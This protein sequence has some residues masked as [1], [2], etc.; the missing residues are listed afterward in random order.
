MDNNETPKSEQRSGFDIH[1]KISGYLGGPHAQM[2]GGISCLVFLKR[3][4]DIWGD[5]MH[6]DVSRSDA[7]VPGL[8]RKLNICFF[9]KIIKSF[10]I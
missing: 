4:A 3:L 1:K 9:Y 5:P 10:I 7:A 6:S 8:E 2:G